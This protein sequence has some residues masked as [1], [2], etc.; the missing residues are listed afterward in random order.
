MWTKACST[1]PAKVVAWV[2]VSTPPVGVVGDHVRVVAVVSV[3]LA[4]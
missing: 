2:P 3:K 4:G 1:D